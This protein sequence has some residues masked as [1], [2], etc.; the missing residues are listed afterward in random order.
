MVALYKEGTSDLSNKSTVQVKEISG[1]SDVLAGGARVYTTSDAIH[2]DNAED[3]VSV[4]TPNGVVIYSNATPALNETVSVKAGV[5]LVS[6]NG[7][8]V[9]VIVK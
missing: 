8:T 1:L 9:K 7:T 5:Y 4:A 6:V 3:K 2:I